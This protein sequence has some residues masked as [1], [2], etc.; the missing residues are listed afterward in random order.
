[1]SVNNQAATVGIL[2]TLGTLG[3]A[4]AILGPRGSAQGAASACPSCLP[5]E[6]QPVGPQ[7]VSTDWVVDAV[8]GPGGC[9]YPSMPKGASKCAPPLCASY[10]IVG[11]GTYSTVGGNSLGLPS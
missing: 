10:Y 2:A 8:C 3:I 5:V 9:T 7:S 6:P 1:M 4:V 11:N